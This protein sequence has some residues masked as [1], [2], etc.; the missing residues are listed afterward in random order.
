MSRPRIPLTPDDPRHGT[1]AGIAAHQRQEIPTCQ[2][3]RDEGARIR[4]AQRAARAAKVGRE[5]MAAARAAA[6]ARY[7]DENREKRRAQDRA[8]Y[9]ARKQA[10]VAVA[11]AREVLA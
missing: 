10:H 3:C 7:R 4:K 2:A 11:G 9:H 1:R 5:T 6:D 8:R